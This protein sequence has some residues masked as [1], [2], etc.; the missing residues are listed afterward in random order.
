MSYL[1]FA[2]FSD[3]YNDYVESTGPIGNVVCCQEV[4]G[5]SAGSRLL[6]ICDDLF[7]STER[8]IG[9]G[10]YFDKNDGSVGIDHDKVDFAGLAGKIP[11]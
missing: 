3:N 8:L 5:G 2:G 4:S 9:A 1:W 6:G 10:L 7:G 11:R